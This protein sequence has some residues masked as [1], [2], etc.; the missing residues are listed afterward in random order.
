ML[1][2]MVLG[3]ITALL[4]SRE[5]HSLVSDPGLPPS[6]RF[7]SWHVQLAIL[8]ITSAG[9]ASSPCI[10]HQRYQ[11]KT[12]TTS[13]RGYTSSSE[14]WSLAWS[15]GSL[16]GQWMGV[17]QRLGLI[18]NAKLEAAGMSSLNSR[19]SLA[20]TPLVGGTSLQTLSSRSAAFISLEAQG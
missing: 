13:A 3:A 16:I 11:A 5:M 7:S 9:S 19:T 15:S 18:E 6:N 10:T 8:W 14:P 12:R 1:L 2:Q 4:R 20:N 17:M